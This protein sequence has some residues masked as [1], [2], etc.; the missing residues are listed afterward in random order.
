MGV[1]TVCVHTSNGTCVVC[2]WRSQNN[3]RCHPLVIEKGS[4]NGALSAAADSARLAW[5][6]RP[7][8]LPI[9]ACPVLELLMCTTIPFIPFHVQAEDQT[10]VIRPTQ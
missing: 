7:R 5:P 8:D 1:I 3:L 9:S 2:I 6:R 10:R 4:L